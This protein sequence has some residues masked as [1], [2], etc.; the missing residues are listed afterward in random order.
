MPNAQGRP[1]LGDLL[2]EIADDLDRP[3]I[4][5]K[6]ASAVTKAIRHYQPERF[7]FNER[8]LTFQ[9]VPGADVYGGG[10]ASEIPGLLAI[11]NV[12]RLENDQAYTLQRIA[13][14]D[15]ERL[16]HPASA[17]QP[18]AYSYFDRSIRL[19]PIP[20]GAWTIRLAAHIELPAP[21]KRD[22]TSPWV[23]EAVDLIAA[24]AKRHLGMSVL[25]DP[26]LAASQDVLANEALR[27][28]RGRTNRIASSGQIRA[29]D[30]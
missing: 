20:S 26:A 2:D 13:E 7:F 28:L 14:T 11:D 3:D 9:T 5:E 25:R 17:T 16:D 22:D 18:C 4:P 15:V 1:T 23:D 8:I 6:I 24:R 30:L 12:V 21:V 29:H 27:S 10:D 19:W